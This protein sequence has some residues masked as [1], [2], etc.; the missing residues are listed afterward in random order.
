MIYNMDDKIF[1]LVGDIHGSLRELVWKITNQYKLRNVDVLICGDFGVGFGRPGSIENLYNRIKHKLEAFNLTIYTIRGNHDNPIYF[2]GKHNFERLI[3]LEDYKT[4]EI[5]GLKILPIG[6]AVSIDQEVR[7]KYNERMERYGSAKRSWW[8]DEEV[9]EIDFKE[10]PTKVDLIV[11][12]CAP[13][14][15]T[16][17]FTRTEDIKLDIWLKILKE[18]NYLEK[19]KNEVNFKYWFFG[20]YHKSTSGNFG[21]RLYR[22]LDI[23]EF[24]EF[25]K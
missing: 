13:I 10:L 11:S 22:C 1:I 15:F 6:G 4:V 17:I 24:Y 7:I 18:R 5:L 19:V 3:F 21:D 23:M 9:K 20:H 25:R 8:P 16:P 2:D 12:H 14:S